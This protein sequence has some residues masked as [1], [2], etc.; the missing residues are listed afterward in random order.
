MGL[1]SFGIPGVRGENIR[2]LGVKAGMG[3]CPKMGLGSFR[4]PGVRERNLRAERVG[5]RKR[6]GPGD[7]KLIRISLV[8]V[9]T[10]V[11]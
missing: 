8:P 9:Y 11:L 3:Q 5:T 6:N 1:G 2:A 7:F 10:R 4:M